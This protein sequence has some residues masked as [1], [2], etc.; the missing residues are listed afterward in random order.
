MRLAI[1]FGTRRWI[2]TALALAISAGVAIAQTDQGSQSKPASF[3]KRAPIYDKT[4]DARTQLAKAAEVAKRDSKR[5]LLMFG[6]DWCGWCHKLHELF[7]S[8]P[9]IC[10]TLSNEY[11]LVMVETEAPHAVELLKTCKSALSKDELQKGVG[12]PFLAVLDADAKIVTALRTDVLEEGDHH[13]PRL[14]QNFLSRHKAIPRDATVVLAEA[15]SRAASDQKRVLLTFGAPWCGWC[16]KLADWLAQPDV[17]AILDREFVLA[18][19]DIDRMTGGKDVME[20]YRPKDS[21]SG[22][23]P[24]YVILDS[25]GK[26]LATADGPKGNIGYPLEPKEID[27]FLAIMRGQGE[28]IESH[29]IDQLRRSLNAAAEQI[30]QSSK[31]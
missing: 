8:N 15:L 28:R 26:S 29:Q 10:Q 23:I 24:W 30:K 6:G 7:A 17:A 20:K 12:F 21:Q 2:A 13:D 19:I 4:A 9:E 31:R 18:K 14:V 11:V 25:Q 1:N 5:I 16:H 22:G 27:Q 3:A